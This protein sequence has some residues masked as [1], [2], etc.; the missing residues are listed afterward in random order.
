MV[1]V[2]ALL[3][4]FL[5]PVLLL[6]TWSTV[7]S[8]VLPPFWAATALHGSSAGTLGAGDLLAVW[9]MLG[10]TSVAATLISQPFFRLIQRQAIAEG[11]LALS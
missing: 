1:E 7:A 4:G 8:W 2:W 3:A 5:F 11:T 9:L 10:L 6:P